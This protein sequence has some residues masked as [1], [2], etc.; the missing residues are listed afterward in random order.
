M[1]ARPAV[2]AVTAAVVLTAQPRAHRR[3]TANCHCLTGGGMPS[4]W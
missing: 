1:L 4:R 2:A 3:R